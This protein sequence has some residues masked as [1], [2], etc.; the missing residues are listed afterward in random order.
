MN[1]NT[2]TKNIKLS[3]EEKRI[4]LGVG[5]DTRAKGKIHRKILNKKIL[6]DLITKQ[7]LTINEIVS[8]IRSKIKI[9]NTTLT[10]IA[11]EYGIKTNNIQ[12]QNSRQD[13]Q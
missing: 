9:S 11:Q 13:I 3:K 6:T 1:I 12:E 5:G 10:K 7:N 4:L 2:F 8:K